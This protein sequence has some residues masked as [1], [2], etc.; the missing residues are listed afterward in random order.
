[1]NALEESRRREE[2]E[3]VEA[4]EEDRRRAEENRRAGDAPDSAAA[5]EQRAPVEP[6]EAEAPAAP[7][8]VAAPTEPV[9]VS[10][11]PSMP[12]PRR[13]T[14][15][16]RP[17]RPRPPPAPVAAP[18]AATPAPASGAASGA[19][20][21]AGPSAPSNDGPGRPQQ[22][23]RKGDDRRQSGKLTVSRALDDEDGAR[24]RSLAALK[25][26]REKEHRAHGRPARAAGQ[27]GP[28]RC[29]A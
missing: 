22:R 20:K 26:A 28:R 8:P 24:A 21:R 19:P 23:D 9:G 12:A 6:V 14:P 3:R 4:V 18:A 27:A 25:R 15:V 1:M 2:R 7:E 10:L 17:E 13:F 11:D 5:P 29:R 16:A